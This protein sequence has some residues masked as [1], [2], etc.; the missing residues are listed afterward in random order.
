MY[1]LLVYP[2]LHP[3]IMWTLS[4]PPSFF[5]FS[6]LFVNNSN[7]NNLFDYLKPNFSK[8]PN[9]NNIKKNKKKSL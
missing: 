9:H 4:P 6:F 2:G 7:N 1:M 8:H 5:F 3:M